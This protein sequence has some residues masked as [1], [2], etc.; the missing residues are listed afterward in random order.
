MERDVGT[1]RNMAMIGAGMAGLTCALALGRAG[2]RITVF[3]KGRA[4][5]GR[6]ATRRAAGRSFNHGAQYATARSPTFRALMTE[7][8]AAGVAAPWEAAQD[9]EDV[10]WTG[11]PGMS[12]LTR[13]LALQLPQPV[14]SGR[15]V[16]FLHADEEGWML[17]HLAAADTSPGSVAASGGELA[18]PFDAVLLALPAPQLTPL[19]AAIGHGFAAKAETVRYAPCWAGMASFAGPITA[20]DTQ[21]RRDGGRLGWV[22]RES[23]RTGQPANPETPDDAEAWALHASAEWSRANLEREAPE[24]AADLVAAFRDL[25]GAPEPVYASAQRWRYALV[26]QPLGDPCLW[27]AASGLGACG[28]WCLGGR[29]EA[30]FTSGEA[31]AAAVLSPA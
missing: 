30:A 4:P 11:M 16:T 21:R 17:R 6:I 10:R 27:D 29:V 18:G 9:G 8:Q 19:L 22:A 2:C 14:S 20:P 7:M 26:E 1:V 28:D 13:H 31:L 23:S 3:D 24:V 12:A 15:Q 5:G 25:T